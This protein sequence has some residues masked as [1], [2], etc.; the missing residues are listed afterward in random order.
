LYR[1]CI[2]VREVRE[3]EREARVNERIRAR[4]V[5]L[6]DENGA[7][8]GIMPTR[9]ALQVARERDLDLIEVAPKAQP[10][11]CRI[12]D[13]GKH[14]YEQAKRDREARKKSRATEVRLLRLRS[15]QIG[16]HDLQIK[17]RKCREMLAEGSK[18]RVSLRF[19]G[20]EMSRPQL[21]TD[22]LNR[23]TEELSDIAQTE[24]TPRQE[25]RMMSLV[26]SPKPGVRL[27]REK[28]EKEKDK[29]KDAKEK[30][31]ADGKKQ[32]QQEEQDAQ[33][34]RQAQDTEDSGEAG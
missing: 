13:Y 29:D 5:R 18:V 20:R 9:Q 26:L 23:V 4:E 2:A 16:A 8:M 12:M 32:V 22:L 19:R 24:G 33:Q 3:I 34:P 11:V 15:P 1:F 10:P 25:G 28:K 31:P 14:K 27:A 7:Q 6:I 21:G 17:L 30:P